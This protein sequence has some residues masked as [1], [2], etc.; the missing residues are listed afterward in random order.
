MSMDLEFLKK[1]CD[2]FGPSG[3]ETAVQKI[4]RDYGQQYADEI[5]YDR[6]GSVILK[7]GSDG[8]KI[9]MAGHGDEIG[10]VIKEI[11]D[12]GFL[13]I[14]NLGGWWSQ[15]LLTQEIL[16]RPFKGGEDIIGVIGA[17]PPHILKAE[18][19]NKVV[20]MSDMFVDIGCAS[21][22]EVKALGIRV[23]DPAVP[24]SFFRTEKRTRIEKKEG[25]EEKTKR[26]VTIGVARNFDNRIGVFIAVE[27]LR[28]LKDE[29]VNH[30]NTIYS[31]STTQEEVGLRGARTAAHVIQPDIGIALDVDVSGDVPGA[32]DLIQKMGKGVVISAGDSSM[33]PNPRLRKFAIEV[34]EEND[35][36]WQDGFL[37]GGG[38]DAGI[39]HITGA[40]APSLFLGIATRHIH[41]HHAILDLDDVENAIKLVVAMV[42]KLDKETVDSFTSL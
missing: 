21:A 2:T 14:S 27:A 25:S 22:E 10:F 19:R 29:G 1:M 38:T 30:P 3:H 18:E 31:V 20:Q 39:I 36:K 13:K 35:I 8:P 23:G 9:M 32:S 37:T 17:K 15:T 16:I 28:R 12:N 4:V 40:G 42:K 33:I 24:L 7:K 34:A 5:S 41:S 11:D 6:M 26:E